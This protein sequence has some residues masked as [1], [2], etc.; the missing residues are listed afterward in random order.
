MNDQLKIKDKEMT[1]SNKTAHE[2]EFAQTSLLLFALN[3]T[4]DLDLILKLN[5]HKTEPTRKLVKFFGERP[6]ALFMPYCTTLE[7]K[8]KLKNM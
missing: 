6:R 3:W 4:E 8:L 7:Y 1:T 2:S 5:E